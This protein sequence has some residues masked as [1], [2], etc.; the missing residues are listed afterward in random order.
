[1]NQHVKEILLAIVIITLVNVAIAVTVASK[2]TEAVKSGCVK[3]EEIT[4]IH[5]K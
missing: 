2:T 5:L 4:P 3:W 1:M